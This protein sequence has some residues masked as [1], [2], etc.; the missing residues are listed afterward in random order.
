MIAVMAGAK[1]I[2]SKYL[3]GLWPSICKLCGCR[4]DRMLDACSHCLSTLARV[5]NQCRRCA[6]VL[7]HSVELCGVCSQRPPAFD[8]ADAAFIYRQPI[9]G[10]IQR[11]KFNGD[12]AAGRLLAQLMAIELGHN[13]PNSAMPQA[14]LM[15][16]VPLHRDRQWR[17]G[18]NQAQ[19]ICRDLRQALGITWAPILKRHR[20]T[21]TQSDLPAKKRAGNVAGAFRVAHLPSGLRHAVL[22]D[23]VMTTGTTLNE[24]ARVLKQ[25][26]L[27][28]VDVWVLARA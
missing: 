23:D 13:R 16:P 20:S 10:L 17:R 6:L 11:F 12:L 22:V 19:L 26:G 21:R 28:R 14:E 1:Y 9:A 4:S 24:C 27:E 8:S 5:E 15:I 18:F 25:A 2:A 7:P 3:A